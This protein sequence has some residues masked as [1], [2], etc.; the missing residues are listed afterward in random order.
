V[1]Q[2]VREPEGEKAGRTM[3]K[4]DTVL[5][6]R[7]TYQQFEGVWPRIA[8]DPGAP[9]EAR[10]MGEDLNKQNSIKLRLIETHTFSAGVVY[11]CYQLK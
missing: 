7:V 1:D 8:K 9:K 2:Y 6:G 11:H 10:S 4:L 3:M 5:F